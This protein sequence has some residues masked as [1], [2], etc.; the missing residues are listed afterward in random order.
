[1]F[2]H[3]R[4][5]AA[6]VALLAS[7][8]SLAQSKFDSPYDSAHFSLRN[9]VPRTQLRK[10]QPDRPGVTESPFTVDAG[11]F[12]LETDAFRIINSREDDQRRREWH[13]AYALAKLGL[14]RR[15]DV[16]VEVPLYSVQKQKMAGETDWERHSGFG[17][18]TLR[19]KHN[20][21][22]DDHQD[23]LA[24]AAIG[25]VRL[26]SGGQAGEGGV[27]AGLV[28]PVDVAIHDHWNL[29][30][31]L[32]TDLNYDRDEDEHYV[33]L[34][35]SVAVQHEFT[36]RL[37]LLLEGVTQWNTQQARWHSSVNVA[38][39]ISVNDNFQVDFGGHFALNRETDREFFV[40]FTLRR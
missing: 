7:V 1:M 19:L 27:E 15:T 38:P 22:G 26:P 33:R 36:D 4:L 23:P 24:F 35:P 8:P 10:L 28:L 39:V 5:A 37:S 40:G 9:P 6:A 2:T 13:A 20:F 31:Q 16:Q 18:V 12:Q 29:E 3:L 11:H 21:V 25:Y 14:S 34:M 17:D 30:A 32:E